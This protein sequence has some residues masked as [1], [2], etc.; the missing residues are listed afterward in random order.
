MIKKILII[1]PFGIG[2]VLFSTPLLRA[3]KKKYPASL[4]TYIC[5]RRACGA[6][7]HNPNISNLYIFEKD[8]YKKLWNESKIKCLKKIHSSISAFNKER[9]DVMVDMSLGHTFSML[10]FFMSSIPV[11]IGLNYRNRGK[12][13][14]HKINIEGFSDKHVVEYYFE[15]GRVLGLDLSDKRMEL[16]VP[17]EEKRQADESL[18]QN[19]ISK[20]DRLC[21]IIPGCGASWGKSAIYRRWDASKFAAVADRIADKYKYKILILGEDKELPLCMKTQAEMRSNAVQLCG[22]TSLTQFAAMLD[23]CDL[24]VTNDGGPLHMAVALDKKTV[25]VFGPVDERVYGPY[26]PGDR[27]ITVTSDEKCRPCYR[28]FK[29]KSCE[30]ISCLKN[31]TPDMVFVA[32]EKLIKKA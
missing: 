8:E 18:A 26:P 2:D 23:R 9:Y 5:N 17:G 22:K 3:I 31:I 28:N 32:A 10:L 1:N 20:D 16:V 15:L 25:S 14:T 6:L 13:L 29:H 30:T 12:F 4:I 7:Q 27:H 21:G 24:V 19:G 11:R